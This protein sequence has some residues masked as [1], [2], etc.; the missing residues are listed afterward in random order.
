MKHD[1]PEVPL[2]LYQAANSSLALTVRVGTKLV[3]YVTIEYPMRVHHLSFDLFKDRYPRR[4]TES[5]AAEAARRYMKTMPYTGGYL[6]E[7]A[8]EALDQLCG[9]D[10]LG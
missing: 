3:Y 5:T 8:R 9:Y 6:T 2:G 7:D 10:L 4:R 1:Q